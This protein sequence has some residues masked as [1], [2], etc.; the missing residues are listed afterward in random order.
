ME[1]T[2]LREL[3]RIQRLSVSELQ[4]EW[5]RLYGGEPCRS[6]NRTYMVKRLCWRV[7]ELAHGG[8]SDR[9]KDRIG[10]LAPD[11]LDCTMRTTRANPA[12]GDGDVAIRPAAPR[13]VRDPRLPSPGTIIVK[14]Y[15]G[16]ELRLVV[17]EDHFELDGQSFNSLSQAA[18][19]VTGSHWN[20]RLFWGL[21]ERKRK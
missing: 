17:H 1:T 14:N 7:Q 2:L 5:S 9:T 16:R 18:R 12:A 13:R 15:K 8:L 3:Q 21:T 4:I 20:G 10:E 19:H 11:V 6:R